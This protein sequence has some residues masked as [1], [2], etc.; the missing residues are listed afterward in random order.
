VT[1]L[2]LRFVLP[3][4]VVL[5]IMAYVLL[6]LVDELTLSWF[7][8]DLDTR[9]SLVG[10]TIQDGLI[11]LVQNKERIH[12]IKLFDRAIQDERL[13]AMGFCNLDGKVIYKTKLFPSFLSTDELSLEADGTGKVFNEPGGAI[14]VSSIVIGDDKQSYGHL[15]L[16]HD[17]SFIKRRSASTK[18]YIFYTFLILG[19]LTSL[20]TVIVA[21]ISWRGWMS[22][23]RALMSGE[24]LLRPITS[25]KSPEL[26]P[27]FKDL[28]KMIRDLESDRI[29]RNTTQ[30]NWDQ[31]SL[32][33][34]LRKE[35]FEDEVI[36]VSNRQ[37]Y[38]HMKEGDEIKIQNPASG[39]VTALEPVVRA[40]SGTW[41]AHG[42][43]SADREVT[44]R[45]GHFYCP[46][47]SKEY[48]LRR[49]WLN[50]E[51]ENGYYYGFSNE[52]LWP[53][54]TIVH[55]RPTFRKEDWEIYK[56][57]NKKFADAVIQEAKTKDPVILIQDYH[58]TLLPK[59]IRE[60]LPRATIIMFWHIPWPNPEV[61]SICPWKEEILEGM[62]GSTTIGFHIQ[63]HCNN[64]LETVDRFMECRID[65]ETMAV[66]FNKKLTFIRN[67][68][69]SIE[70][71]HKTN[72]DTK[73]V[74]QSRDA[75][76]K[77]H[78]LPQEIKIGIGIDRMDYTKGLQEKLLSIGKFFELYPEWIGKMVFIQIASPT[79]T[80]IETY[81]NFSNRVNELANEINARFG[82]DHYKPVILLPYYHERS[83][84]MAYMKAADFCF[85]SSL[86]DGMNLVA[87]E[88][89]SSR[90]DEKGVLILSQFAGASRELSEALIINPYDF[91]Q[92]A[93]SILTALTM[94][95][96][97][98]SE[99]MKIM[100]GVVKEFNIFRWAGRMLLDAGQNRRR[101]KFRERLVKQS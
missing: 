50:E 23:I 30:L 6:P 89:I 58:F 77:L 47:G 64:F 99:R 21:N 83:E 61:F 2:S 69:I 63:F 39:V 36:V 40:C 48:R 24:G 91:E 90:S 17:M 62:L 88:F 7:K 73:L 70:W 98:Q 12:I 71:P 26:I 81:Q 78:Q 79:R 85:I 74:S 43:G 92:C 9:S 11:P 59:M 93:D 96:E 82:S 10:I 41:I 25:V 1:K 57:V 28:K 22:G 19:I 14:H 67:Y 44:D 29:M 56:R 53:L 35:L 68:P 27:I 13:L 49:V 76:I 8:R 38:A 72:Q 94:N 32:K 42:N 80:R 18:Q 54:C 33:N 52:G 34:I 86:H 55:V 4:I 20:V 15:I 46:P 97:E 101:Q 87:K 45:N 3:L 60:K 66:S 5:A 51:E 16:V 100:R 84:I 65:N 75:V 31:E 37:P 95:E